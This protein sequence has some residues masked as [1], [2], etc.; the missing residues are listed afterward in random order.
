MMSQIHTSA[1]TCLTSSAIFNSDSLLVFFGGWRA[2]AVPSASVLKTSGPDWLASPVPKCPWARHWIPVSCESAAPDLTPCS[3]LPALKQKAQAASIALLFFTIL[4]TQR[5]NF[6][7]ARC[8]PSGGQC[9]GSALELP[10][11]NGVS[12]VYSRTLHLVSGKGNE[13]VSLENP[14][15]FV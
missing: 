7:C 8:S 10:L 11:E 6:I 5:R 12:S 3:D 15:F 1:A 2:A 14:T 4:I 13:P 9:T